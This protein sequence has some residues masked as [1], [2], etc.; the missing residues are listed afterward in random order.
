MRPVARKE[1]R[2]RVRT[3]WG[4]MLE[5]TPLVEGSLF[6]KKSTTQNVF[7]ADNQ[8]L[9]KKTVSAQNVVAFRHKLAEPEQPNEASGISA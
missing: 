9:V 7:P 3:L 2:I 1:S 8:W 5:G 4:E 6:C